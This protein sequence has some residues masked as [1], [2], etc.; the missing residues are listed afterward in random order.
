MKTMDIS[1]LIGEYIF[2]NKD[3]LIDETFVSVINFNDQTDLDLFPE[4]DQIHVI[5]GMTDM[6]FTYDGALINNQNHIQ[7]LDFQTKSHMKG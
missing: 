4:Q 5:F 7:W 6:Y 3:M 2:S 1:E